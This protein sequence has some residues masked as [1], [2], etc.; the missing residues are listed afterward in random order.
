LAGYGQKISEKCYQSTDKKK[1]GGTT[2]GVGG[3]TKAHYTLILVCNIPIWE[4][5]F[6][7]ASGISEEDIPKIGFAKK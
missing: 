5:A 6:Y 2:F 4:R 3:W 7:G 1:N